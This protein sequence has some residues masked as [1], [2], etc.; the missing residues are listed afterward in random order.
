MSG[1]MCVSLTPACREAT[2]THARSLKDFRNINTATHVPEQN[3][4]ENAEGGH[5][6]SSLA[7]SCAV[8]TAR[9]FLIWLV[10][11]RPER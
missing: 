5:P 8:D 6:Q 2:G 9:S 1:P 3:K 10:Y 11:H 4:G 7:A